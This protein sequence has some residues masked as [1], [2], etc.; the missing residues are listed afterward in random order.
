MLY[1]EAAFRTSSSYTAQP[2]HR[3]L[4]LLTAASKQE[5]NEGFRVLNLQVLT[6]CGRG[7]LTFSMRAGVAVANVDSDGGR[8]EAKGGVKA[9]QPVL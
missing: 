5:F 9:L 7:G 1:A 2:L 6:E 4:K 8:V 3:G